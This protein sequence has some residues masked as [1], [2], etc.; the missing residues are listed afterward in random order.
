VDNFS[1]PAAWPT[2]LAILLLDDCGN[3]ISGGQIVATFSNGDPPL[4][5]SAVSN[6][7]GIYSGTWTPRSTGPQVSINALANA[8]GFAAAHLQVTGQVIPNSAPVLTP[9][10]TLHVF[11][12]QVGAPMAPGTIVQIYGSGLAPTGT[13]ASSIPLPKSMTQ[14][15]LIIGGIIAPLYYVGPGQINAQIPFG[16]DPNGQYQVI[17]NANGSFTAPVTIQLAPVTPGLATY[18]DGSLIAQH[19]ADGSLITDASPAQPGENVIAYLAGLGD[20]TVPVATGGPSPLNPLAWA[21]VP[22][23]LTLNGVSVPVQFAG[24]TPGLVGLYQL[25]FQVP[26][27]QPDGPVTL[28]VTQGGFASNTTTLPVHH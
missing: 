24:L 3:T 27:A 11:N 6:A 8:A 21:G 19:W 4:A 15:S 22:P 14:T 7:A 25:N 23:S 17:A 28:V 20:T 10:G 9:H 16:L 12:P 5:L 1:T 18:S 26:A 13:A 2:P